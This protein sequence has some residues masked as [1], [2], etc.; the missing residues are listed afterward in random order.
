MAF[1][2]PFFAFT[3]AVFLLPLLMIIYYS[4]SGEGSSLQ[5]YEEF[6]VGALYLR[7]LWTT[8]EVALSTAAL[9]LLLA[10]PVAYYLAQQPPKRRA[11]MG[12]FLLLPFYTSILVKSFAFTVFLGYQGIANSALRLAFGPE[13]GLE[14]MFNRF[15]VYVGLTHNYLPYM[16][17]PIL[18]SLLA[19]N[20][21]LRK[22]AEIMGAEPWRIFLRVTFPLS[23][24]GVLAGVLLT[25]ILTLGQFITPSLLGG[26][27]DLMMA[28]LV[29]FHIKESLDWGMASTIA[30][31]LMI[32]ASAVMVLLAKVRGGQMFEQRSV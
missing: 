4:F 3:A 28:N 8:I 11:I 5:Y 17:F 9:T 18:V 7:V 20:P 23:M 25:V 30:V 32:I 31:V 22:A 16:V 19:Q 21:A 2:V 12:L 6:F 26:R 14:M 29:D 15:G 27:K 1:V 10:Y 24:P 13:G